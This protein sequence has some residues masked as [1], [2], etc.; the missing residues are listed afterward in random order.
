MTSEKN[1]NTQLLTFYL[2]AHIL[3]FSD[4]NTT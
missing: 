2:N 1:I 4:E 3:L